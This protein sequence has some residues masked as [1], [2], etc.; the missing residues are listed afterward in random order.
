[1]QQP[2]LKLFQRLTVW[3]AAISLRHG[4]SVML[5]SPTRSGKTA[6]TYSLMSKAG[7]G[8]ALVVT[9]RKEIAQQ[10]ADTAR[11]FGLSGAV[12]A[13]GEYDDSAHI[14]A[15]T[16]N[17]A[18]NRLLTIMERNP[19]LCFLIVDEAHH[20]PAP[21]IQ[22]IVAAFQATTG[23]KIIY[24]TAT[25]GRS[26]GQNI[27]GMLDTTPIVVSIDEAI[28]SPGGM[29]MEYKIEEVQVE[30]ELTVEDARR[31]CDKWQAHGGLMKSTIFFVKRVADI[32][33][34][35]AEIVRRGGT[36]AGLHGKTPSGQRRRILDD[37]KHGR[38]GAIV[39]V[40]VLTEG[41]DVNITSMVVIANLPATETPYIQ[42]A[43][44]A[45]GRAPGKPTP[46]IIVGRPA[47]RTTSTELRVRFKPDHEAITA[48]LMQH[49][50]PV[51]RAIWQAS[52]TYETA[53]Q[54][55]RKR[56][57]RR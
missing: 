25:P 22:N 12:I 50:N 10:W 31:L 27:T 15:A 34:M 35:L 36:A 48:N 45:I 20:A 49:A 9:P 13:D 41:V 55:A 5:Q 3:M 23:G 56:D 47:N 40:N 11:Q 6:M 19:D 2:Q 33:I 39:N 42:K 16:Y 44:R 54:Q 21:T 53:H 29:L 52:R 30:S 18:R 37:Y 17:S 57:G 43:G 38:L 32:D 8:R 26:D 51:Q 46:V 14:I 28:A 24:V 7:G 1:M 4:D